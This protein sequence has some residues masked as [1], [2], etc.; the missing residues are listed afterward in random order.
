[1]AIGEER[2]ERPRHGWYV[3]GGDEHATLTIG[4]G[5]D[6]ATRRERHDGS[7]AQL[8]FDGDESEALADGGDDEKRG[9]A[10]ELGEFVLRS[11]AVPN[12][13]AEEH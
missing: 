11:R 2:I 12:A 8:R 6:D 3:T 5:I 7:L 4:D 13:P 9:A 1:V 10:I